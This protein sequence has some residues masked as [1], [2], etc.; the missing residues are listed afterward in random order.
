MKAPV[1]DF[2]QYDMTNTI[3]PKTNMIQATL[4]KQRGIIGATYNAESELLVVAYRVDDID[5]NTFE[6]LIAKSYSTPLKE[7]QFQQSG[8]KCP[9]DLA[10]ISYIKKTLCLRD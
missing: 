5:R 1:V 9:V 4:S 10:W 2:V 6:M 7:K 3:L 8:S